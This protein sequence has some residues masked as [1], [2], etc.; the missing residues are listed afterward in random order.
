MT[1]AWEDLGNT[2]RAAEEATGNRPLPP[3]EF[4]NLSADH[5]RRVKEEMLARA[6]A[7]LDPPKTEQEL[8]EELAASRARMRLHDEMFADAFMSVGEQQMISVELARQLG[9]FAHY[10][11]DDPNHADQHEDRKPDGKQGRSRA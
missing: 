10:Q 5:R 4:A 11:E 9:H 6:Q 3:D 8:A 2:R 1:S 7:A